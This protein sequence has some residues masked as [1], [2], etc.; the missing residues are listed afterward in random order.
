[1]LETLG[2]NK[3]TLSDLRAGKRLSFDS[4]ARIADYLDCSMDFLAGRTANPSVPWMDLTDDER[5][6]VQDYIQFVLSQRK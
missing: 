4:L 1:M 5:Q 2:L 6:K 3:N